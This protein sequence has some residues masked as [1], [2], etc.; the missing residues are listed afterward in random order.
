MYAGQGIAPGDPAPT[1]ATR[2]ALLARLITNTSRDFDHEVEGPNYP[3][4]FSPQYGAR[5]FSGLGR[6]ELQIDP[7][8]V[9]AKV[10]INST[11]GQ[12]G[13]WTDYSAELNSYQMGLLPGT[14]IGYPKHSIYR[15]NSFYQ[16]PFP[17]G[18]V[19]VTALWGVCLA[20]ASVTIPTAPWQG[21]ATQGA[22]NAL[23][24]TSGGWWVTPDDVSDA[25]AEWTLYRFEHS[26]A[27]YAEEPSSSTM[28]GSQ[29]TKFPADIP[30]DVARII[31]RYSLED[32]NHPKLAM[33]GGDDDV[34]DPRGYRWADWITK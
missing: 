18:N 23:G 25:V 11:P 5:L 2:D 3:G 30:R 1:D 6:P 19:R 34:T 22:V 29:Q 12:V 16:D 14:T 27:A 31:Q 21:V 13:T 26:K 7:V 4:L 20:D 17:F 28:Q 9:V 15:V 24:P 10:E 8:L 33:V 32:G